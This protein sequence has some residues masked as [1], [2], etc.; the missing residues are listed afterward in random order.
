MRAVALAALVGAALCRP[1][2]AQETPTERAA[3][4]SVIRRMDS[5]ESSLGLPALVA[6]LTKPDA[7]RDAVLAR[8]K[9]LMTQELL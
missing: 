8:V 2:S 7:R 4:A 5:L 3:A 1:V 6:R 9:A